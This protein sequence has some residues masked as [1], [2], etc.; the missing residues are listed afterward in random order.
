METWYDDLDLIR[1]VYFVEVEVECACQVSDPNFGVFEPSF[2][3]NIRSNELKTAVY[4]YC[5][6]DCEVH[7]HR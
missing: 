3:A 4:N 7:L 1:I 2:W 6:E 5:T